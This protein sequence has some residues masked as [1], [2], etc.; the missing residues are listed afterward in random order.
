ME[1]Y[2]FPTLN[3]RNASVPFPLT[4]LELY[5]AVPSH[6]DATL[7]TSEREHLLRVLR[8]SKAVMARIMFP[9]YMLF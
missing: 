4:E 3:N 8:E 7:E 2:E 1:N 5:S 9:V 6:D